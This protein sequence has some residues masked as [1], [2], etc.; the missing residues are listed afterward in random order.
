MT[1]VNNLSFS[2]NGQNLTKGFES[3]GGIPNLVAY[4]DVVGVWTN[5]WGNT[6]NVVPDSTI[7][8]AQA[9]ADFVSNTAG[10]VYV[11]NQVVQVPLNQNQF[12][13]LVDFVFNLGSANFQSSTLLRELNAGNYAA[14]ALEFPKWNHAGG[15]VEAGLTTRRLAEQTLFNTPVPT[16]V[17]PVEVPSVVSPSLVSEV[18]QDVTTLEGFVTNLQN[19]LP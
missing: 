11:V 10:A 1:T 12:D 5:G 4:R 17:Q 19:N 13:A 2:T 15:V 14:A 7:T 8:L 16:T 3:P 18:E 9:E 6:H